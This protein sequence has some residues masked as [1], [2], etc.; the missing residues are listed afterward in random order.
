MLINCYASHSCEWGYLT[1]KWK[2]QKKSRTLNFKVD[3]I[4]SLTSRLKKAGNDSKVEALSSFLTTYNCVAAMT[5]MASMVQIISSS[6]LSIHYG[7]LN[8]L[9]LSPLPFSLKWPAAFFNGS[10]HYLSVV[11]SYWLSSTPYLVRHARQRSEV[12][13]SWTSCT[14][15]LLRQAMHG[16]LST[17]DQHLWALCVLFLPIIWLCIVRFGVQTSNLDTI[18]SGFFF[19]ACRLQDGWGRRL[20]TFMAHGHIVNFLFSTLLK[21]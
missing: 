14:H 9:R 1:S 12:R 10:R 4:R 15:F 6:R 16:R 3:K 11:V 7:I 19:V 2:R 5:A 8:C 21:P 20:G 13:G 17:M 18:L